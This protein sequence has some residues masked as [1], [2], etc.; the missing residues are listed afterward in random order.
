MLGIEHK[1]QKSGGDKSQPSY[2]ISL[3]LHLTPN[4]PLIHTWFTYS[5]WNMGEICGL[6][7]HLI[8]V[9]CTYITKKIIEI[10]PCGKGVIFI[11]EFALLSTNLSFYEVKKI[12]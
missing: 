12:F 9:H 4:T 5:I 2:P 3:P 10:P 7:F 6:K 11:T 8:Y 1:L